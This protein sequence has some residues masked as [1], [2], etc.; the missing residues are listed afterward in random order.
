[1]P[2]LYGVTTTTY[3]VT[4]VDTP[5]LYSTTASGAI[6]GTVVST[7][8]PGLY[9][10]NYSALPSTAQALLGYFDNNG[11]VGFALDPITNS[12]TI[13]ANVQN[14]TTSTVNLFS[15]N[16]D[17]FAF[18]LSTA[19]YDAASTEVIVSGVVQINPDNYTLSGQ[20]IIFTEAPP[21]GTDNIQVRFFDAFVA[22]NVVGPTGPSGPQGLAGQNGDVGPRGPQGPRGHDGVVGGPGP[23]GPRGDAGPTGPSGPQGPSGPAGE[24]AI[25]FVVLGTLLNYTY[26]PGYPTSYSGNIGDAYFTQNDGHLWVWTGTNWIDVGT[27]AGP[28]GPQGPQGIGP[29]GPR[30]PQGP[31]GANG[32]NGPTG[33]S[34]P[35]GPTNTIGVST[36]F[37]YYQT[38]SQTIPIDTNTVVVID[39]KLYDSDL[40]TYD[41]VNNWFK[42]SRPGFYQLNGNVALD[43]PNFGAMYAG[44]LMNGSS[45]INITVNDSAASSEN[46]VTASVSAA[47]YFNGTTDY[48]QLITR[49]TFLTTVSTLPLSPGWVSFSGALLGG[50]TANYGPT[51]PSGPQGLSGPTG[52]SGGPTGPSG[53]VGPSGPA[54]GGGGGGTGPTG[55]SG[56]DG[57]PGPTG[58]SGANGA[59]G[60]TGPSGASGPTGPQGPSTSWNTILNRVGPSGPNYITIGQNSTATDSSVAIGDNTIANIYSVAVGHNADAGYNGVAIGSNTRP[61]NNSVAVGNNAGSTSQST[62]AVAV[63]YEAGYSNQGKLGVAVGQW[64][65]KYNQGEDAVAVGGNAATNDQGKGAVAVGQSAG[66]LLMGDYSI[67][68]GYGGDPEHGPH[69]THSTSSIV[70]NATGY[71]FTST[72]AGLYIA[73]VRANTS[74]YVIF[75]NTATNEMTYGVYTGGGGSG[76]G[77]T[78]PSGAQGPQGNTGP[79]GPSGGPQGPQGPVGP[80][81]ATGAQGLSGPRGPQG[82][83]GPQGTGPQGPQGPVGPS[84]ANYTTWANLGDKTGTSGPQGIFI[85]QNASYSSPS[86]GLDIAI[87]VNA[88]YTQQGYGSANSGTI[89]IGYNAGHTQQAQNSIAIGAYSAYYGLGQNAISI[90]YRTG[91]YDQG[92]NTRILGNNAI[93]IGAGASGQANSVTVSGSLDNI[94]TPSGSVYLGT[95]V[96]AYGPSQSNALYITSVRNSATSSNM[97]TYGTD[98]GEITTGVP[99]LPNFASDTDANNACILP[100]GQNSR[101]LGSM[102]YNTALNKVKVWTG[103]NWTSLL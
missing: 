22:T 30:G 68:L 61:G 74:S 25:G 47:V 17:Q 39:T 18:T 29:Q 7:N 2:G 76:V 92:N 19:P 49:Q 96:L 21:P 5:T 56:A 93:G 62:I 53:P 60:P 27:V 69:Y 10:G 54:G 11:T 6:T 4:S 1:M 24:N 101:G 15:G 59:N 8:L 66:G 84:G 79:T 103:T 82:P 80:S 81:G 73:P 71:D 38:T 37:N 50:T 77:P 58:P 32:A 78:G 42:P 64:A 57:A 87:G 102:Y 41:V 12:A 88:G 98:D 86:G 48:A 26:L 33:P 52:P 23:Q 72:N 83:T 85:G 91:G 9:G 31:Q 35:S 100:S 94:L 28:Q 63:G 99:R 43:N 45:L 95:P 55:P 13:I 46:G 75:Y 16:N 3:S 34:G 36:G 51:G 20:T 70:I 89:A 67:Y 65:G 90:G 40:A 44:I 97:L 14:F